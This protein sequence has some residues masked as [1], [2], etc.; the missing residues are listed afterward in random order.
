[1]VRRKLP[2]QP[3]LY[4]IQLRLSDI[5]LLEHIQF[6]TVLQSVTVIIKKRQ[7]QIRTRNPVDQIRHPIGED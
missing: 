5:C 4:A 7:T 3:A 6:G 1:M 2:R